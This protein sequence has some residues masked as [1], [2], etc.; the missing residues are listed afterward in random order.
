MTFRLLPA[1]LP[2]ILIVLATSCR[3][4]KDGFSSVAPTVEP[5]TAEVAD[6][7]FVP[8][9]S[10]M[11][12]PDSVFERMK[13]RS[14]PENA[15]IPLSDL[16]YLR[17]SY[18]DFEGGHRHGEMVCNKV[19]ADDL[20]AIF[21]ALYEASYPIASIRLVDDFDGSDAASMAADNTSCFNYRSVPG[22]K[23]LS[24]HSR[25]MAVDVNPLENP[26]VRSRGVLP[27]EGAEY[28]DRSRDFPHKIDHDDLCYKVFR[29]HGFSWG[30]DW[31]GRKDYQHFV[32][33]R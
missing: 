1:L 6:T 17:L 20:V 9:F 24:R 23:E 15:S 31:A 32:R 2:A 12:I 10:A 14:Y 21:K 22:T 19:I 28:A 8:V 30:G 16:R 3:C 13:G 27:P 18:V 26:F 7:V 29:S 25:G 33:Y 4:R 5:E 11:E